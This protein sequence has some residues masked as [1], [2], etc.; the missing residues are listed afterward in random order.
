[1]EKKN[2][3]TYERFVQEAIDDKKLKYIIEKH[4]V[5]IEIETHDDNPLYYLFQK[6][7]LEVSVLIRYLPYYNAGLYTNEVGHILFVV[8]FSDQKIYLYKDKAD[9]PEF[10]E[11][12]MD[13]QWENDERKGLCERME[14]SKNNMIKT[15]ERI[16]EREFY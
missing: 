13:R 5:Q 6:D 10:C 14:L 2:I 8:I 4:N 9:Y 7:G 1:M 12:D 11:K 15:F 3:Q 16:I